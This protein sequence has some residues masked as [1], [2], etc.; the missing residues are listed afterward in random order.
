MYTIRASVVFI[1]YIYFFFH[2]YFPPRYYPEDTIIILSRTRS[3]LSKVRDSP[4]VGYIHTQYIINITIVQLQLYSPSR[5]RDSRGRIRLCIYYYDSTRKICRSLS[6]S[7]SLFRRR[8]SG[9]L[10]KFNFH[11]SRSLN[12]PCGMTCMCV[13]HI[14]LCSFVPT[15][16]PTNQFVR[17]P[18]L[19][20]TEKLCILLHF[21]SFK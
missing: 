8:R 10:A 21:L 6:L 4:V 14:T 7:L 13:F 15:L 16:K 11:K 19:F 17:K 5:S 9:E 12:S 20:S 1:F 2:S 3:H 18:L